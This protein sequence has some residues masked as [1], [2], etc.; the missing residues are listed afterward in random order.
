MGTA[1]TQPPR[2][3]SGP[4]RARVQDLVILATTQWADHPD[5]EKAF[6]VSYGW[7]LSDAERHALHC[8]TALDAVKLPGLG[9]DNG[10]V[11]V[12]APG[13]RTLDRRMRED[14]P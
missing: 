1:G 7:E 6:L 2:K 5:R 13:G 11:E 8:L 3:Q 12:T 14:R 4:G 10:D 9:P